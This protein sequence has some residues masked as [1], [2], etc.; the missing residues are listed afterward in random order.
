MQLRV[1]TPTM[2]VYHVVLPLF[3]CMCG[4]CGCAVCVC[5]PTGPSRMP[6]SMMRRS[7]LVRHSVGSSMQMRCVVR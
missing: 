4:V 5:V 2:G 3:L 1:T 6:S 7:N